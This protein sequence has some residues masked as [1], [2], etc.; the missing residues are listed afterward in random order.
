METNKQSVLIIGLLLA[1]VAVGYL[2][3]NTPMGDQTA[4][5]LDSSSANKSIGG[6][7]VS[8]A[9]PVSANYVAGSM[10]AEYVGAHRPPT[11]SRVATY[12]FGSVASTPITITELKFTDTNP[13]LNPIE[14]VSVKVNNVV[15]PPVVM[16]NGTSYVT[17]MNL[18]VQPGAPT[19][20]PI[21][22]TLVDTGIAG[23]PSGTQTGVAVSYIKWQNGANSYTM[24][25]SGCTYVFNPTNTLQTD[26]VNLVGARPDVIPFANASTQLLMGSR[27][28][29]SVAVAAN[30]GDIAVYS[31]PLT[32]AK[33]GGVTFTSSQNSL[34]VK[35][36]GTGAVIPTTSASFTVPG[37]IK[38]TFTTPVQIL[39]SN[40]KVFDVYM[41]FTSAPTGSSFSTKLGNASDF[42]WRDIAGGNATP[43]STLNTTFLKPWSTL[44]TTLS[45]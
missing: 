44:M 39:S 16:V 22:L 25:A 6:T 45:I 24:C 29:F 14:S 34:V 18:S 1:I 9:Y 37:S 8:P 13:T 26:T 12:K 32:L 27:K 35:D 43:F 19:T 4:A 30:T 40:A 38:I 31:L 42:V 15:Y 33:T 3:F 23:M 20:M 2:V 7:I 5:T 28:I 17:G 10:P 21:I 11:A 36:S 41:N